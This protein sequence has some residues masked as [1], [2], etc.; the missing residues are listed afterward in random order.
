MALKCPE[1]GE[2]AYTRTSAYESAT[3]KRT[4]Y[5]CRNIDCSCTFTALESVEKIIMKPARTDDA[6]Q[7]PEPPV[8]KV[9]ILNR[10]GSNSNLSKRQ[11]IPI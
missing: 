3:V 9:H 11:Q 4:W 1:C 2:V 8:K 5:Q 6:E 7:L 10:Y